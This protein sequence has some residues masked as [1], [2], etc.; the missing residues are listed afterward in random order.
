[1]PEKEIKQQDPKIQELLKLW[2]SLEKARRMNNK[3]DRAGYSKLA[4][5]LSKIGVGKPNDQD[6]QV[7][8]ELLVK[9]TDPAQ[10]PVR[11][12]QEHG[13]FGLGKHEHTITFGDP[14]PPPQNPGG[15]TI[16]EN[17]FWKRTF[18]RKKNG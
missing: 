4:D 12:T 14:P 1:M 16:E 2:R 7:L 9:H 18:G 5:M 11:T 8:S 13:P 17:S 6:L 15:I 3:L 10:K